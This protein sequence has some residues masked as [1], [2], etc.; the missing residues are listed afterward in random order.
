VEAIEARY[1]D[2]LSE[3]VD[4][5]AHHALQGEVWAKAYSYCRQ[6]GAKAYAHSAYHQ[7]V[8]C[9]EQALLAIQHL[10]ER[11]DLMEQ[12]IEICF[13]LRHALWV[14]GDVRPMLS[15]LR[16]AETLAAALDDQRRLGR[17]A[18]YMCRS[19]GE[20]GDL[21]RAVTSG[22]RALAV[23]EALSDFALQILANHYLGYTYGAL[24]DYRRAI[25]LL[26]RNVDALEGDLLRER[27]GL[28]GLPAVISRFFLAW[29]LAERGEYAE[30][31]ARG[32]EAVRIAE[33]I[34]EPYSR[35][36]AYQAVGFLS[37]RQGELHRA[38]ATLERG[39][40]LFR[41]AN[42]P[43]Q[44]PAVASLLGYAYALS[45]RLAKALPLLEQAVE[46]AASMSMLGR[47]SLWI[48]QLSEA[49]MRASR[50]EEASVLGQR[51]LDLSRAHKEQGHQAW[52][53]RLLGEIAAQRE[54]PEV[55]PA[56]TSYRQAIALA[57]EL[58]MRPLIAHCHSGLGML[59]G[60]IGRRGQARVEL[61]TAI[62]LYR[63]MAMTFW[64]PGAE[65]ALAQVEGR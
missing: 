30:G 41:V 18:A 64:L 12:A 54:P 59:H 27:F 23:A 51:A 14:L 58:G 2:R 39:R 34:D 11:R 65:A 47:Q 10:P 25:E 35:I 45:G 42:V 44:V 7:A 9:L 52:A 8:A 3:R 24:G 37:L 56:E 49:Y 17:V 28:A 38:I 50:W 19:F 32:E 60:K 29:C 31:I 36:V 63:A 4:R 22:Q 1:P 46:Q 61:S 5:L 26:R 53:L 15:Y 40:G 21:D 62:E 43:V 13:D 57:E 55:E 33:G 20:L 48:A 16:E 6:A